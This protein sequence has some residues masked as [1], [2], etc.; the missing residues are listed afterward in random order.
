METYRLKNIAIVILL[1]LN[2]FLLVLL[3]YQSHQARREERETSE[4]L[5]ELYAASQLTLSDGIDLTQSALS[6]LTL[7]RR[8]ETEAEIAA[9]L[10]GGSVEES[11]QGGGIVSYAGPA[12]AVQFRAGGSFDGSGLDRTVDDVLSF[13]ESFCREFGY[14]DVAVTVQNGTGTVTAGQR[15]A[16]VPIA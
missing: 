3:G 7:S 6:P 15:M 16:G 8:D 4:Q 5:E 11:R 13:A 10:L 9:E 14:D 12:G 2:A 1:L